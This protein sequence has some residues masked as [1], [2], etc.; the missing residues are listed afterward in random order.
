MF[1]HPDSEQLATEI[2]LTK[3]QARAIW[4]GVMT[5]PKPAAPDPYGDYHLI[6]EAFIG[7]SVRCMSNTPQTAAR[8]LL[9]MQER[10][11]RQARR[12]LDNQYPNRDV[13]CLLQ[14]IDRLREGDDVQ[15]S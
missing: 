10:S 4:L 7:A 13:D 2:E 14:I 11:I 12:K 15:Q 3:E 8:E 5:L 9:A 6:G 1:F